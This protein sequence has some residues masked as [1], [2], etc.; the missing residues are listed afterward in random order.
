M[1]KCTLEYTYSFSHPLFS[2]KHVLTRC[3]FNNNQTWCCYPIMRQAPF[4]SQDFLSWNGRCVQLELIFNI[5]VGKYVL[6][7]QLK[8]DRNTFFYMCNY[9]PPTCVCTQPSYMYLGTVLRMEASLNS[10]V[11]T[12]S[13]TQLDTTFTLTLHRQCKT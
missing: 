5:S 12:K 9:K 1:T 8:R 2:I 11:I 7:E 3:N 6:I 10:P 13:Y 4:I